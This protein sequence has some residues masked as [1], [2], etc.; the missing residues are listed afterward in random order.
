MKKK[1]L[2]IIVIAV[3]FVGFLYAFEV[4]E[5]PFVR[6]YDCV[7]CGDC[8]NACPVDAIEVING[9]AVIDNQK[10]INCNICVGTCTY[11]AIEGT[12]Q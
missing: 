11:D 8:V 10:C 9:K 5:N 7:G 3:I 12:Q 1:L 6:K 2:S 4:L